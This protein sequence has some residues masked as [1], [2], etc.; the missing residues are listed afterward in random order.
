MGNRAVI[1]TK[2][3]KFGIYVHWNGGPESIQAFLETCKERGYRCPDSDD[4]Y[5]IARLTGVLHEFFDPADSTCVGIGTLNELDCDN[6]DNGVYVIGKD[7]E[8][9]DWYGAGAGTTEIY[10]RI[11]EKQKETVQAIKDDLRKSLEKYKA[12]E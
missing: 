3:R 2:E 10:K 5:A 7:W 8:V 1:T 6:G 11:V 12:K 9:T 4:N